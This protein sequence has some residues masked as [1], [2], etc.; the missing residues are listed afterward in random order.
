VKA[1]I[2][3]LISKFNAGGDFYDDVSGRLFYGSAPDGVEWPYAIVFSV[4][5]VTDDV[6]N[7]EG[8]EVYIQFSL[9]SNA[10][11]PAEIMDM[12]TDLSAMFR[13]EEFTVSGWDVI[14][15]ARI[16]SSGPI[17]YMAD[18]EAGTGFYWQTD[19]DYM[20]IKKAN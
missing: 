20:I 18:V 15:M 1:L 14:N 3:G 17:Y 4:S 13:D 10:S 16:N 9:F 5:D 6:F 19:V 7:K 12:E 8:R 2:T 11:S